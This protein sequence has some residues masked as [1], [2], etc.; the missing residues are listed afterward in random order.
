MDYTKFDKA[1]ED[2]EAALRLTKITVQSME[3]ALLEIK[4]FLKDEP[5]CTK[6]GDPVLGGQDSI[7]GACSGN[8]PE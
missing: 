2:L 3:T 4:E 1:V 5:V 6:C 7:C 8:D